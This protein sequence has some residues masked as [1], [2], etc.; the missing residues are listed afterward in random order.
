[1]VAAIKKDRKCLHKD[2]DFVK[3]RLKTCTRI[4]NNSFQK[5]KAS[6]ATSSQAAGFT[7]D[8]STVIAVA[9]LVQVQQI[10]K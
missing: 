5:Y 4:K 3:T 10:H 1:M 2:S 6:T 9:A 7:L 8:I